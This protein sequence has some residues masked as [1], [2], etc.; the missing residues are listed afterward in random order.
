MYQKF[1]PIGRHLSS[2]SSCPLELKVVDDL[3]FPPTRFN[4]CF[5][6]LIPI[7]FLK[8]ATT[9]NNTPTAACAAAH[10]MTKDRITT[11][12][13]SQFKQVIIKMSLFPKNLQK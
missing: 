6:T 10:F 4:T 13:C 2:L 12:I 3:L 9:D 1:W 8:S 11:Q 5:N 7:D